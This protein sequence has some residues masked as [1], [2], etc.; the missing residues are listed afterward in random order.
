MSINHYGYYELTIWNKTKPVQ[1]INVS[2]QRS[3][4][5]CERIK[6]E[7]IDNNK[8]VEV[9]LHRE[10]A[11]C[12]QNKTNL[13]DSRKREPAPLSGSC[14]H[15]PL[16]LSAIRIFINN[17]APRSYRLV[18][19]SLAVL[20]TLALRSLGWQKLTTTEQKVCVWGWGRGGLNPVQVLY[21]YAKVQWT[22][23]NCQ[24]DNVRLMCW[25]IYCIHLHS[26][27]SFMWG[28]RCFALSPLYLL[29]PDL[30]PITSAHYAT[31][32]ANKP[33]SIHLPAPQPQCTSDRQHSSETQKKRPG[34]KRLSARSL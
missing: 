8:S 3:P 6:T 30:K 11:G 5:T 24:S 10:L 23:H 15:H 32:N 31:L 25:V 7:L 1:I 2:V 4:H 9:L 28:L 22:H 29:L 12:D 26:P 21:N 17:V 18:G 34:S 33:T 13:L 20:W 14:W 19:S 27:D 16:T